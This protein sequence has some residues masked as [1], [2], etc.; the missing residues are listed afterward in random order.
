MSLK[1]GG[2]R[3]AV[4]WEHDIHAVILTPRNWARVKRGERQQKLARS[5]TMKTRGLLHPQSAA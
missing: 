2:T 4:E 1:P 3:I 5:R